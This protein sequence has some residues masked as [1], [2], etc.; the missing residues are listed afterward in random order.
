LWFSFSIS[1][2]SKVDAHRADAASLPGGRK[3]SSFRKFSWIRR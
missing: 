2:D 3:F 1:F